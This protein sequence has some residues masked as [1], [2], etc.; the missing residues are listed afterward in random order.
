MHSTNIGHKQNQLSTDLNINPADYVS[1]QANWSS[2]C[3]GHGF[4]CLKEATIM[5]GLRISKFAHS[6][7]HTTIGFDTFTDSINGSVV[8]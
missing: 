7:F 4:W 8:I 1:K 6:K 2:D 5:R 3:S